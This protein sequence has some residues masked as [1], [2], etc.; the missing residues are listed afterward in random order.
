MAAARP[1][2]GRLEPT[3][4]GINPIYENNA[5]VCETQFQDERDEESIYAEIPHV[6]LVEEHKR[7]DFI[8]VLAYFVCPIIGLIFGVVALVLL[9]LIFLGVAAPTPDTKVGL[10]SSCV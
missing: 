5:R 2:S 1:E 9:L 3:A 8:E 4:T 7:R 10:T 6:T